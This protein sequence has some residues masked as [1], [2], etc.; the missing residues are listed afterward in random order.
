MEMASK[1]SNILR[2]LGRDNY[3]PG[4]H[5]YHAVDGVGRTGAVGKEKRHS[6][7]KALYKQRMRASGMTD[8]IYGSKEVGGRFE[9]DHE[10]L[11]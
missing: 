9:N 2:L 7:R 4:A 3:D 1:V 8:D 11:V 10:K 5:L 6:L